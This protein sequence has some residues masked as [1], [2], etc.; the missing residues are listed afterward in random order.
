M[1][2]A[3]EYSIEIHLRGE[4]VSLGNLDVGVLAEFLKEFSLAIESVGDAPGNKK[5]ELSLRLKGVVEGSTG[6]LLATKKLAINFFIPISL[7]VNSEN[8]SEIPKGTTKHLLAIQNLTKK[9]NCDFWVK[10]VAGDKEYSAAI[11]PDTQIQVEIQVDRYLR[12]DT[13]IH[14]RIIRVGGEERPTIRLSLDEGKPL[15]LQ[16]DEEI[17]KEAGERLYQDAAFKGMAKINLS[18]NSIVEFK[19][20]EMI[21]LA[22]GNI[23]DTISLLSK[24]EAPDWDHLT[25]DEIVEKIRADRDAE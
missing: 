21:A 14:G 17:A 25:A 7:A 1:E 8:Y 6:L 18:D 3:T 15:T 10:G 13:T 9:N 5:S 20:E 12:G 23:F 4:S 2:K 22:G 11:T 19:V 16:C 24:Y